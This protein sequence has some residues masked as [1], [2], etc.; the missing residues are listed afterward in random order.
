M[1][2]F[3]DFTVPRESQ[4]SLLRYRNMTVSENNTAVRGSK[5]KPGSLG[6]VGYV[7]VDSP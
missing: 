1:Y 4:H 7:C 2:A 6:Q 5:A 3:S